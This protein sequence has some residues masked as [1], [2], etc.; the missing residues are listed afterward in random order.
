[1]NANGSQTDHV[2]EF[3]VKRDGSGIIQDDTHEIDEGIP[4]AFSV[5]KGLGQGSQRVGRPPDAISSSTQTRFQ[6]RPE[7]APEAGVR[8]GSAGASWSTNSRR[9][10][11]NAALRRV[12]WP[13][14]ELRERRQEPVPLP[15]G[16]VA[17]AASQA[18]A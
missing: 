7:G 11:P 16:G 2:D 14:G 15:L 10:R 5:E 4:G 17:T 8:L 6:W 18:R 3:A 1:M 9:A 12:A 13:V